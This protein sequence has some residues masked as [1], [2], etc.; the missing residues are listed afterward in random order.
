M[1][2]GHF[3]FSC[4]TGNEFKLSLLSE[5]KHTQS[6][7]AGFEPLMLKE[8]LQHFTSRGPAFRSFCL[9]VSLKIDL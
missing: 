7:L 4:I 1:N 9:E 8:Y 3:T 5:E 6:L 2:F